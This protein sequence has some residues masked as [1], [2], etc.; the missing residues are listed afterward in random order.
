M[1]KA[2][3]ICIGTYAV[4][5]ST[6]LPSCEPIC[7]DHPFP[8]IVHPQTVYVLVHDLNSLDK[9]IHKSR[10]MSVVVERRHRRT[11]LSEM[12][13][14]N[15]EERGQLPRLCGG[16]SVPGKYV[17]ALDGNSPLRMRCCSS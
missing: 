4:Y 12:S 13:D 8:L 1:S 7:M 2:Q 10:R 9:I 3:R 16:E 17:G 14:W 11:L 15:D 5:L 6:N